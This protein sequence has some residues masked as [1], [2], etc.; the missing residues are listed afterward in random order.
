M[1]AQQSGEGGMSN[2][3]RK[4]L[5]SIGFA[6][7]MR[8]NPTEAEKKL[9]REL[10]AK[11]FA[12]FKFRRQEIIGPYIADFVCLSK[13]LIIEADGS[14]HDIDTDKTR[15]DYLRGAGFRI[16]RF[17]NFD[18]KTNFG[19]VTDNIW[20]ALHNPNFDPRFTPPSPACATR[21]HPTPQGGG[22]LTLF[23]HSFI[24][25]SDYM[26][27]CNAHYYAQE[28]SIGADFIT[29]PEIS[30]MF[31]E[32]LGAW[33]IAQWHAMGAPPHW[34]LVELGPGRGT[35]MADM[36]R[37]MATYD[38]KN[39]RVDFVETSPSLRAKQK[40][41]V[42][43]FGRPATWHDNIATL[44]A[45]RSIIIA[46]EFLDALPIEQYIFMG[47]AWH[48]RGVRQVDEKFAWGTRPA[49]P[50]LPAE[51]LPPKE[52]D[53]W[54]SSAAVQSAATQIAQHVTTHGGT[55]LLIDYGHGHHAF[56]DTFQ[57]VKKHQYAD[58]LQNPGSQDL[59]A[60]V[61][62]AAVAQAARAAG[63]ASHGPIQQGTFLKGL[64]IDQ[65]RDRL[66]RSAQDDPEEVKAIF[67]AHDRLTHPS[68]MGSLFK[69]MAITPPERPT[70]E[71]F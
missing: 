36:L 46:N 38:M 52:G 11:R 31:G 32:V 25:L 57:A 16:L 27:A 71:G 51:L 65:R 29:A 63:A 56:G 59:T 62:F 67:A 3:K 9:W 49:A 45:A 54:E 33:A 66:M 28:N 50:T 70:P 22:G 42:E 10:R 43:K 68:K 48:E 24:P 8:S 7:N 64:G 5:A 2:T 39:L 17:S 1:A 53:I 19:M 55:A 4:K 60:H 21:S 61:N 20:T 23:S 44:P 6:K 40:S 41:A 35:L 14:H 15:D 13:K 58:P 18:I 69:V 30:Q 26:A 37:V 47:S 34:H 12:D